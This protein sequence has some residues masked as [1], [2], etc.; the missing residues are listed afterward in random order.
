MLRDLVKKVDKPTDMKRPILCSRT[1]NNSYILFAVHGNL[2]RLE[3]FVS[4]Q[5]LIQLFF[6]LIKQFE[7]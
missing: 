3:T 1:C 6:D 4:V 5:Q 7:F 2:F